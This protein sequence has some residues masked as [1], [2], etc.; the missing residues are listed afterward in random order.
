M[1]LNWRHKLAILACMILASIAFFL[2]SAKAAALSSVDLTYSRLLEGSRIL[3]TPGELPT[4]ALALGVLVLPLGPIYWANRVHALSVGPRVRWVGWEYEAGI[5]FPA[6][7]FFFHH[8]SEHALDRAHPILQP[9]S[10]SIAFR[11]RIY[12]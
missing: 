10:N 8:H 4:D 12:P 7:D 11:W 9:V 6:L 5:R 3:E 2:A 1:R